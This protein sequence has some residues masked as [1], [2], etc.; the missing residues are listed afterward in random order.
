MK[1]YLFN[2]DNERIDLFEQYNEVAIRK[3]IVAY[4]TANPREML[5]HERDNNDQRTVGNDI[6]NFYQMHNGK[7]CKVVLRG[8]KEFYKPL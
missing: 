8:N 7:P 6:I 5:T 3:S 1:H 2:S 4:L